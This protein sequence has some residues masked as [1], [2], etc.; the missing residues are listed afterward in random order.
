MRY[1]RTG[2]AAAAILTAALTAQILVVPA[3][4]QTVTVLPDSAEKQ[5][6]TGDIAMTNADLPDPGTTERDAVFVGN[7]ENGTGPGPGTTEP[8]SVQTGSISAVIEGSGEVGAG[9]VCILN[10]TEGSS[11]TVNTGDISVRAGV[12]GG[13][14]VMAG[15]AGIEVEAN[16]GSVTV[17]TGSVSAE[18][19]DFSVGIGVIPDESG[20]TTAGDSGITDITVNG[21]IRVTAF[22]GP[23]DDNFAYGIISAKGGGTADIRVSGNVEAE[24]VYPVGIV[25]SGDPASVFVGGDVRCAGTER[26]AGVY[27]ENSEAAVTVAGNISASANEKDQALAV[28]IITSGTMASGGRIE[29]GGKAEGEIV[30]L[31]LKSETV[32]DS[33][34]EQELSRVVYGDAGADQIPVIVLHELDGELEAVDI[35]DKY[36]L[37]P[38]SGEPVQDQNDYADNAGL[39]EALRSRIFYTVKT[40]QP[41]DTG[42]GSITVTTVSEEQDRNG[43]PAFNAGKT[44][45]IK[46]QTADGMEVKSVSGGKAVLTKNEDGSYTLV[47]PE[48]GGVDISAVIGKIMSQIA[49]DDDTDGDPGVPAGGAGSVPLRSVASAEGGAVTGTWTTL[50]DG[51]RAF[52][53]DGAQAA[54]RWMNIRVQA[55]GSELSAW[56]F[57]DT[58]GRMLTGWQKIF[59]P[60]DGRTKWYYLNPEAGSLQGACF[61]NTVTP[62]GYTV[63]E[64]GEWVVNGVVQTAG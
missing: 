9:G 19:R 6:V 27:F 14:P 20:G 46:V 42:A 37:D 64:K 55:A 5:V 36:H 12:S 34:G 21:D 24:S 57:F 60:A 44:V 49:E 18:G 45:S 33:T 56:F 62:D 61:L 41:A 53:F 29:A 38:V 43:N 17:R 3:F 35:D 10:P 4:A 23:S 59:D 2:K 26:A 11:V 7:A 63:N 15:A 32:Y 51:S 50:S 47:I 30:V 54:D 1:Q 25:L 13:D 28:Y 58:A 48:G 31:N 39:L 40:E 52:R 8:I 22:G 16:K